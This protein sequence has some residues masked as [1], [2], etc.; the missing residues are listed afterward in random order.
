MQALIRLLLRSSLIRVYIVGVYTFMP[1]LW[2]SRCVDKEPTEKEQKLRPIADFQKYPCVPGVPHFP[3]SNWSLTG[4]CVR[5]FNDTTNQKRLD[6][7]CVPLRTKK[8]TTPICTYSYN[9]D[10]YVSKSLQIDGQW[11]G[12]LVDNISKF[13]LT[14]PDVEFLDVGCNI[15]TYTLAVANLGKRVVAID[16]NTD[17]LE[18]LYKSLTLGK[19]HQNVTLIWNAVSDGYS[20]V[21]LSKE[22]GNVGGTGIRK[23]DLENI[24]QN[25][26]LTQTI[27][28]DDLVPLFRGK[29]IVMK[30]DIETSEYSALVGGENFF[31][32]VD[33]LL[34]QIE[35]RWHKTA[36]T[37]PKIVEYLATRHFKPFIDSNRQKPLDGINIKTWPGDI[38]FIKS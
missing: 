12:D 34:I 11:E 13:L 30:M 2:S 20:K 16:A 7:K 18:L 5:M 29:R 36:S 4:P 24:A 14:R 15:G 22:P 38:Y 27:K 37:G 32:A 33:V 8:G 3:P 17:S 10:I 9:K 26:F 35:I 1:I 31:K 21:T 6:G 19:L 28:L 25:T 23:P